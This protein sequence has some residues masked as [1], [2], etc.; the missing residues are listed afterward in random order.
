MIYGHDEVAWV[1][2]QDEHGKFTASDGLFPFALGDKVKLI[3]GH[4]DPTVNLHDW[5]VG[6]R[7]DQVE[8]VW[9]ILA[10]GMGR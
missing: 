3:P 6:V 10:R 8:V 5:Y 2:G 4:C 1:G 9:P 7:G